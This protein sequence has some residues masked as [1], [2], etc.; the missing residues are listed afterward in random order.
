MSEGRH[1]GRWRGARPPW[2]DPTAANLERQAVRGE[3]S[4]TD[5]ARA[6][7]RPDKS[8]CRKRAGQECVHG[9]R[10]LLGL[11]HRRRRLTPAKDEREGE[12]AKEHEEREAE[13]L[14]PGCVGQVL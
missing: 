2:R 10:E 4:A 9:D 11:V 12:A 13:A 3:L 1:L 5:A 8:T 14:A 7:V 6:P